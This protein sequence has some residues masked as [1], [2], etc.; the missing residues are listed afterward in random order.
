MEQYG[1]TMETQRKFRMTASRI[2]W[3]LTAIG[4]INWG[5]VAVAN[6]N[7]VHALFG[8]MPAVERA[9]YAVVGVFGVLSLLGFLGILPA[10]RA[11][12]GER[13]VEEMRR[14]A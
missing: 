5:L 14:A 7:L 3:A 12:R 10:R 8:R 9:V 13:L 2:G 11:A 1:A 4:A 6:F